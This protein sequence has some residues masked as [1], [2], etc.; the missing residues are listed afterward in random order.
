[1]ISSVKI[2][3]LSTQFQK[4]HHVNCT[5]AFSF[6]ALWARG[7]AKKQLNWAVY[8]ITVYCHYVLVAKAR[9]NHCLKPVFF[10][11]PVLLGLRHNTTSPWPWHHCLNNML[12]RNLPW[13]LLLHRGMKASEWKRG[14]KPSD[15]SPRAAFGF[16]GKPQEL[17]QNNS[18]WRHGGHRDI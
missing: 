1:M 17:W 5:D 4:L 2:R 6:S 8:D 3:I 14:Q 10:S 18:W 16:K 9:F 15:A 11:L 13:C 12:V 7:R